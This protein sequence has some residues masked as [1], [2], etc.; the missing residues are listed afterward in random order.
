MI[1]LIEQV[2]DFLS[3]F[4]SIPSI[5]ALDSLKVT[6]DVWFGANVTLKV[7]SL[8]LMSVVVILEAITHE[9]R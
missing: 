5:I 8:L 3:R 2:K 7:L 1:K 6:G 4:K 9:C